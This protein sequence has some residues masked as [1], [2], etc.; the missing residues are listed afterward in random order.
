MTSFVPS[1]FERTR[2]ILDRIGRELYPTEWKGEPEH[3]A[4][5]GLI[6]PEQHEYEKCTPGT[7][8]SGSRSSI[9]GGLMA[10]G[11][12]DHPE[13]RAEYLARQ[14][15][16][17]ARLE[18]RTRL[19]AGVLQAVVIEP[20]NGRDYNVDRKIWRRKDANHFIDRGTAPYRGVHC[21][22]IGTLYIKTRSVAQRTTTVTVSDRSG[23]PGA[24]SSS[25][26]V[27]AE[28]RRRINTDEIEQSLAKEAAVLSYW[29]AKT[30]PGLRPMRPK[31]IE[32]SI[33]HLWREP[34]KQKPQK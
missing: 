16:E 20:W 18:L 27:E 6:G 3:K 28:F 4:R 19:E 22:Q 1:G 8:S 24:P 14:R 34:K 30:H 32:N 9:G 25:H 26:L 33:R 29:L 23:A 21:E 15:Y 11:N 31:T 2:D 12:P 10:D 17:A 7:G 13:Y 5:A